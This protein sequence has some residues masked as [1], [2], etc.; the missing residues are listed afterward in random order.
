METLRG[1]VAVVTGGASGMGRAMAE[2]FLDEGMS[3]A[4]GDIEPGALQATA[5]ALSARGEVLAVVTDVSDP[6]SVDDLAAQVR[7][8]FGAFHVVCNNAGV[9]GHL[10]LLWETPL[11][12]WRWVLDVNLMGVIH[13][14]RS[15]VPSLVAQG[16]GHVVNTASLA[17]WLGVGGFAPYCVSKHGVLAISDALRRELGALQSGV[18]VSVLCPGLVN[19]SLMTGDRNWPDRLGQPPADADDP[20]SDGIRKVL[21]DGTTGGGVGPGLAAAAVVNAIRANEFIVTTHPAEV[22]A[23]AEQR[24]AEARRAATP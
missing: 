15:F 5:S 12:D 2:R 14:I 19:T 4:I 13:G 20:V 23:A 18:G 17:A 9:A 1:G 11:E 10:G 21:V 24:L 7:D 16:T 6:K 22:V 3:V 8:R